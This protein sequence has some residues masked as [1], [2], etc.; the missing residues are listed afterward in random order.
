MN[1]D[2]LKSILHYNPETGAFSWIKS[3]SGRKKDLIAGSKTVYG[4]M[5]IKI[6]GRIHKAHR[7]VWLYMTGS[8]PENQIDHINHIRS[9]NRW[10]NLRE[11]THQENGKNQKINSKNTSGIT[12]I[13]MDK[14]SQKWHSYIR[15]NGTLDHIGFFCDKFEAICARKSAERKLNFHENHGRQ[16]EFKDR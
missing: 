14:N 10:C 2:L 6:K 15:I 13:R 12:G 3:G 8:W 4:Y 7:L 1:Q 9:D 11:A 5:E 16:H